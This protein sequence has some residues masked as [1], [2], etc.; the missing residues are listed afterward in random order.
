MKHNLIQDFKY[1]NSPFGLVYPLLLYP[2]ELIVFFLLVHATASVEEYLDVN[3]YCFSG[4]NLLFFAFSSLLVLVSAV[5]TSLLSCIKIRQM[6][7]RLGGGS[8]SSG[9]GDSERDFVSVLSKS[10]MPIYQRTFGNG[11][12]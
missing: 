11:R 3:K 8:S 4:G 6:R 7:K 1:K 9:G 10:S 12:F 2:F 5:F